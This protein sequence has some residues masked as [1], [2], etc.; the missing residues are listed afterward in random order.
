[1]KN[2]Y[3]PPAGR[4]QV[5]LWPSGVAVLLALLGILAAPLRAAD[6]PP[7]AAPPARGAV[8]GAAE[9]A[10]P[11]AA[12][13][14]QGTLA[15]R[16]DSEASR[17]DAE[18]A[19]ELLKKSPSADLEIRARLLLCDYYA[20]RDTA[21]AQRE[22]AAAT[23]LLPQA[24]R[25]GLRAGILNCEGE[26]LENSGDNTKAMALYTEAVSVATAEHDD[27]M[28]AFSLFSH[29]YLLGVV[30]DY[31]N[32]L[33]E[34]RRAEALFEQQKKPLHAM[35]TLNSIATVY[36]R[37]GD[38][39]Q[40]RHIYTRALVEQRAAGLL[41]EEVVTLHNLG[42]VNENL[43]EWEA[44]RADFTQALDIAR[45][46]D[47]P[48][49]EAYALRGL[50]AV[51]NA[52]GDPAGAL[53]HLKN[54]EAFQKPLPDARLRAQIQ[55]A[56]GIALH[57]LQRF[58]ESISSLLSALD[59][60]KQADALYE[61]NQVYSELAAV[62]A[63]TG[64]WR[65]AYARL[66]DAKN[67]SDKLLKNQLDRGF[68]T[69]KVEFDTATRDKENA[70]LKRENEASLRALAQGR[71]VRRLQAAVIILAI[72]LV[73]LL[74]LLALFQHRST[75]RMHTLAMTDELTGVPNRRAVLGRLD[76]LLQ[77]VDAAPCAILIIDIDY[78]KAIND[79]LGHST[80]DEVLKVVAGT[81][82]AAVGE[83]AFFGR[84][85][86]EEFLIVLPQTRLAEA[87]AAAERFCDKIRTIDTV[88]WFDDR[89]RIT[90][91]IGV[92]VSVPGRDTPSTMLQRADAALYSA[93]R[94]GRNCVCTETAPEPDLGT[95]AVVDA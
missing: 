54:A 9:K 32:G 18:S 27:D 73:L 17:R 38:Y 11:A 20:E 65:D 83:P 70:A 62:Y 29:G 26:S 61:L 36:N 72:S 4:R 75:L 25:Q 31:P 64:N 14:E 35:T 51:S 66:T 95:A 89:R 63:Q 48:R 10:N 46:L 59:V 60:F 44:A 49:G 87:N 39:I 50:A 43:H 53:E 90:C 84:L 68:A 2:E 5:T 1:M 37:M 55:L 85:G 78:F 79:Q 67:T 94:G 30:G 8:D 24:R 19:L 12:L 23:A 86:G 28:L 40:A 56:R 58:S 93:K 3:T 81:V 91:S 41:R 76:R 15:M 71:S 6:V 33:I 57:K 16:T 45:K 92:S 22:I 52:L 74:T 82:R 80:G 69:L 77:Q 47:Y 42:R 88:R 34:L 7:T 21:A 13:I